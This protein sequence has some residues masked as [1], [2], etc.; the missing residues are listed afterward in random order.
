VLK[1][2]ARSGLGSWEFEPEDAPARLIR[3]DSDFPSMRL[4]G[5]FA[6]GEAQSDGMVLPILSDFDR[7]A[8]GASHW[9]TAETRDGI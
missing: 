2:I 9:R 8:G 5:Q 4:N 6:K 3:R 7:P 1:S